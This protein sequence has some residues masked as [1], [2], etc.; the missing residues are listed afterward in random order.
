MS[1]GDVLKLL[2][3]GFELAAAV[4]G[5]YYMYKWKNTCWQWFAYFLLFI[6]LTEL[7][8]KYMSFQPELKPKNYMVYRYANIPVSVLFY[9]WLLRQAFMGNLLRK[10]V[11]L[12]AIVYV[13]VWLMEQWWLTAFA[14][15]S[16]LSMGIGFLEVLLFAIVWLV[17]LVRSQQV[18]HFKKNMYFWLTAGLL[19]YY[20][21]TLPFKGFVVEFGKDRPDILRAYWYFTFIFNYIMYS[22]FILGFKWAEPK[23][24]YPS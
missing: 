10:L 13:A 4:T 22:F 16:S 17:R 2:L 11:S 6:L 5:F 21:V 18:I 7:L 23:S 14:K 9:L 8:A 12:A 15:F 19:T 1:I 20:I 24:S 3:N